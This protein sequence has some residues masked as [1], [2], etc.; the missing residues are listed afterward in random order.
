[1]SQPRPVF[2][3]S[4]GRAGSQMIA[5]ALRAHPRVLALHEPPPRLDVEAYGKWRGAQPAARILKRVRGKR[6]GL[7]TQVIENGYRYVESS[8]FCAHLVPELRQLFDA[9]I[10]HLHRDVEPFV[11]SGLARDWYGERER[12]DLR[13]KVRTFVRRRLVLDLGNPG[14]DH[15]LEPPARFSRAQKIAWLWSQINEVILRDL[16]AVP[17]EHQM[18][19]ALEAV[20]PDAITRLLDLIEVDTDA[21]TLRAMVEIAGARPN[22][23]AS[24]APAGLDARDRAS[25][26]EIAGPMRRRLGYGAAPEASAASRSR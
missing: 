13:E 1:M 20:T 25:V 15:R 14:L 4:T 12:G 16:E 10:V 2:V 8:H 19:L 17:P 18:T 9:R 23:S 5:H 6:V 21:E 3:V 7:V 22:R 26:E 11:A 24:G